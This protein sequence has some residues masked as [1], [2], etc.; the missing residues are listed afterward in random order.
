VA[1]INTS[2]PILLPAYGKV[3]LRMSPEPWISI[4]ATAVE[5]FASD[6]FLLRGT[7]KKAGSHG[8]RP[9]NL[10]CAGIDLTSHMPAP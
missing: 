3:V 2:A 8:A 7:K 9:T 4:I 5:I 6:A 10:S 1:R